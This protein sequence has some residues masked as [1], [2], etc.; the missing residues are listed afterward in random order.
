MSEEFLGLVIG[1][2]ACGA[3]MAIYITL[4]TRKAIRDVYGP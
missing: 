2:V 1:F 4:Q 3:A